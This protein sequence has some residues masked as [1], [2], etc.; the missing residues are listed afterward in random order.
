VAV[1]AKTKTIYVCSE[2][3]TGNPAWLGRCP[4]CGEWNSMAQRESGSEERKPAGTTGRATKS[5]P[6]VSVIGEEEPRL[7]VPMVELERVLGGG[8]VL[9]SVVLLAGEPGIGKS[10]LALQ[11]SMFLAAQVG[12]VLYASGEESA[13]QVALRARRLGPIPEN[14]YILAGPSAEGVVEQ[15][16]TLKPVVTVVD[17]IQSV[18]LESRPGAA[19]SMVQVRDSAAHITRAAK[20]AEMPLILVGH[21]TKSGAIAGPRVLE[22]IVDTVLYM[23][24]DRYHA[25]R[26]LRAVKNRF[27]STNEVGVLEMT[28]DGLLEV[29]NPSEAFLAERLVGAAG[30]AV[31]VTM[32]GTRPILVEVQ[33]LTSKAHPEMVRRTANGFDY[34]RLL[35]LTAVLS[36]RAGIP[37]GNHDVFVNVVGGM[38]L[39]EPAVDLALAAAIASSSEDRPLPADMAFIGEIG[40][41]GEVRSVSQVERR[42]SEAMRLGF[43][44]CMVP[45]SF[46]KRYERADGCEIIPVR[47]LREAL[48]LAGES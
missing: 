27:G 30:S 42:V 37:L 12:P 39:N 10:T 46:G 4:H 3:G 13:R 20:E 44:S 11:L 21:V 48:K 18:R 36:K 15:I 40:L 24:G 35:L 5:V 19:G 28:A 34:R 32:E 29:T 1:M 7:P 47:S 26:I 2:C 9:G 41:S 31:A 6:L 14:L 25:H 8:L 22:H 16:D 38:T 17:S 33:A 45:R 43:K 23:E